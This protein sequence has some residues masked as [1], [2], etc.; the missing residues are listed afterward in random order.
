[1]HISANS[2]VMP[3][4]PWVWNAVER[5]LDMHSKKDGNEKKQGKSKEQEG[6]KGITDK[7]TNARESDMAQ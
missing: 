5:L 3:S 7:T 1:M 6:V 2:S 4:Y